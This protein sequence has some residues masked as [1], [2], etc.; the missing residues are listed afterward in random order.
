M[1]T[2]KCKKHKTPTKKVKVPIS[3]MGVNVTPGSE[4]VGQAKIYE[5]K[6]LC[7]LCENPFAGEIWDIVHKKNR[8]AIIIVEGPPGTGKSYWCL[9]MAQ[10]LDPGFFDR[11]NLKAEDL[12]ARILFRPADFPKVLSTKKLYKGAVIIIEEGGVQAD[13]RKWFTFN[14][15]VFNY[16]FQIFR[17]M[18]LIVI[19]NVPVI[20]YVDSDVQ[21][22]F[23]FHVQTIGV[24]GGMN[25]VKIM[26]QQYSS[27]M[28]K[29]YRHHLRY[30]INGQWIK[31]YLWDFPRATARLCHEYEKMHRKF[32]AGLIEQMSQEM[33]LLD[34]KEAIQRNRV[35]I[36]E[37]EAVEKILK[38][39]SGY[40]NV[41]AGR[42]I[43]NKAKIE[44]E[45]G[46]GRSI[47][48]RIKQRVEMRLNDRD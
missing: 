23:Q 35:L 10:Y 2:M 15:M 36:N 9:K 3:S 22:L 4:L 43:V 7:A 38:D 5:Y 44:I 30:K 37:D 46:V 18:N 6:D 12:E 16:I 48:E 45:F 40:I 34:K 17:Y 26:R 27:T 25:R 47:S 42:Q 13:H 19:M 24:A 8:N 28:K 31:F 32:K 41:R 14:N 39:P 21:K 11:P 1:N 33:T 29:I 20:H